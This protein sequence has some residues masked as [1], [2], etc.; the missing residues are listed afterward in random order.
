VDE[1]SASSQEV[2]SFSGA[3]CCLVLTNAVCNPR[4]VVQRNGRCS[5]SRE[6]KSPLGMNWALAVTEA[7]SKKKMKRIAQD[8]ICA[9]GSL[10]FLFT[11][12]VLSYHQSW[13][14]AASLLYLFL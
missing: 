8:S 9:I 2:S 3:W 7:N 6:R 5:I 1:E 4:P 10:L 14:T 13:C 11:M 12:L